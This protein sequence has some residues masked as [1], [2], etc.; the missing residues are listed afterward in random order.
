[1]FCSSQVKV[2]TKNHKLSKPLFGSILNR[3]FVI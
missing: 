3:G 2:D 1:M